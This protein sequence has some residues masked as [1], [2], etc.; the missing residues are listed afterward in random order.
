CVIVAD[1][2]SQIPKKIR[3]N[4]TVLSAS[5]AWEQQLPRAVDPFALFSIDHATRQEAYHRL[6]RNEVNRSPHTSPSQTSRRNQ[7]LP[8]PWHSDQESPRVGLRKPLFEDGPGR[9]DALE[10]GVVASGP[11]GVGESGGQAIGFAKP[12]HA[13]ENFRGSDPRGN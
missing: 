6:V 4:F 12:I 9:L 10:S 2:A 13:F 8:A 5:A 7:G 3:Q 1:F 11:V